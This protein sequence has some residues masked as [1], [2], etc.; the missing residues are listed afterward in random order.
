MCLSF[1]LSAGCKLHDKCNIERNQPTTGAK[2]GCSTL[3]VSDQMLEVKMS[4]D[5]PPKGNNKN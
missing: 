5:I 3:Y 4:I 2:F 1:I